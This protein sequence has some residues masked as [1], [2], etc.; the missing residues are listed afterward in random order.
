MKRVMLESIE[1]WK[2]DQ[3]A[4]A[5]FRQALACFADVGP[6]KGDTLIGYAKSKLAC[7]FSV[8]LLVEAGHKPVPLLSDRASGGRV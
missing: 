1:G 2:T 6:L 7:H 4:V 8:Q 5:R 3:G